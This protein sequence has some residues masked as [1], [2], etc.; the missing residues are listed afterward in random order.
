MMIRIRHV[1]LSNALCSPTRF[2]QDS[3]LVFAT[4]IFF[5]LTAAIEMA[6]KMFN[7]YRVHIH[8]VKMLLNGKSITW[9]LTQSYTFVAASTS[10]PLNL[11]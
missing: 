6:T 7:L 1:N 11:A 10:K 8:D 9:E 2:L 5:V 3:L 4:Y